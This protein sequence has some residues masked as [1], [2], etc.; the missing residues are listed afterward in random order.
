MSYFMIDQRRPASY[1]AER[2]ERRQENVTAAI[3][4]G[5]ILALFGFADAIVNWVIPV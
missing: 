5:I 4:F 1:R 2:R 3:L